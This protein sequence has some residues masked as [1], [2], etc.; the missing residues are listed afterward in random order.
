MSTRLGT[1]HF[2]GHAGS[3]LD[4]HVF[5]DAIVV[6]E[7]GRAHQ[8]GLGFGAIGGAVAATSANRKIKRLRE[9]ADATGFMSAASLAEGVS[10][11]QLMPVGE[12]AG[13][14]LEKA[15]G[16]GRKLTVKTVNGKSRTYRFASNHQS[17]DEVAQVVGAAL[18]DRFV[19][20][21][22]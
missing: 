13:A 11:A 3:A 16:K 6:I 20:T 10:G 15:L 9:Q 8:V 21:L 1:L 19:N 18:G 17:P 2:I 14:R 4:F 5:D 7:A 12:V 22:V